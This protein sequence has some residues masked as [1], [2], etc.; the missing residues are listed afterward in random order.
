MNIHLSLLC[1]AASLV[2]TTVSL[3]APATITYLPIGYTCTDLSADGSVIVG[4]VTGDGSYETFRWTAAEGAVRLGR[5]TVIPLGVGAGS[6]DVSYDGTRISASI[7]DETNTMMTQGLWI[8]GFWQEALPPTG[9][10]GAVVD[11]SIGSSWGLSGDGEHM[12]GFYWTTSANAHPSTWSPDDGLAPLEVNPGRSARVNAANFD[13]SVVVGWEERFDGPWQP[14]VW[15]DGLKQRLFETP[16][17]GTCEQVT[18]D[19]SIV[20]GK[21]HNPLSA[22]REAVIWTWNGT[23]YE[24][25]YLGTLHGTAVGAGQ[26]GALGISD[27]GSIVVGYNIFSLAPY[28]TGD[29]WIR[30]ASDGVMVEAEDYLV[31]LGI[32]FP[33]NLNIIDFA[34]I[35]ADGSTV[36]GAA[37]D[38]N[39]GLLQSFVLTLPA[40][41]PAD[42]TCAADLN[43]DGLIDTADLG[44]LIGAFGSAEECSDTNGDGI[45]DTADLGVLIGAFGAGCN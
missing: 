7:I 18:A 38:I 13:G 41:C 44:I 40:S 33:S 15:R 24:Q 1:G 32:T 4:N 27:N 10:D 26:S 23:D 29:G 2:A 37:L 31:S 36:I 11:S 6:P 21:N 45:V 20:I 28:Y 17:G 42:A 12:T 43:G 16:S 14:T 35:S 19:G 5:G 22:T 3:A 25:Q 34:G 8:N 39:N 30:F 9:P